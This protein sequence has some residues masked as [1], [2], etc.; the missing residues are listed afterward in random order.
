M[1]E[2]PLLPNDVDEDQQRKQAKGKETQPKNAQ[3]PTQSSQSKNA[4]G[5]CLQGLNFFLQGFRGKHRLEQYHR[6][7]LVIE[8]RFSHL[9]VAG[10]GLD[11]VAAGT[12][13]VDE[14]V[15]RVVLGIVALAP[16]PADRGFALE[17]RK[18]VAVDHG[19]QQ[20]SA[21]LS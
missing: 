1:V 20:R 4:A 5:T 16:C 3:Q 18:R 14:V 19:P 2:V 17:R 10:A 9:R 8:I 11:S 6:V 21:C 15:V 7:H 13:F 12:W